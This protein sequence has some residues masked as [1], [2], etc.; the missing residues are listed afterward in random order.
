[1]RRWVVPL[2]LAVG[3]GLVSAAGC[4]N[5]A[6]GVNYC[7]QIEEARCDQAPKCPDIQLTPPNYS[8]GS[9]VDAC[10]RYY[11]IACLNGLQGNNTSSAQ[12]TQ[13]VNAINDFGGNC[14]IV[15][16]PWTYAPMGVCSW[17]IPPNTPEAGPDGDASDADTGAEA[18]EDG[19]G[20]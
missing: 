7:K 11:D 18:A 14:K 3:L 13:C 15:E 6:I 10:K 2:A 17:L 8:T 4:G 16:A 5:S 1:M 19:S 9:A 20:E 12:V